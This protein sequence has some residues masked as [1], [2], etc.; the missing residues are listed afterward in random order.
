M[1]IKVAFTMF[2]GLGCEEGRLE[3]S[4]NVLSLH[5]GFIQPLIMFPGLM[6]KRSSIVVRCLK[7]STGMGLVEPS[8]GYVLYFIG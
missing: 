1:F 4:W 7:I 6:A 3:L 2:M 8:L 5:G